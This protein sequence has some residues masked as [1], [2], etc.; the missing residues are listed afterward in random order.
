MSFNLYICYEEWEDLVIE[1]CF[2][3]FLI[4]VRRFL[5]ERVIR[6]LV[7]YY[8]SLLREREEFSY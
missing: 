5:W 3:V 6:F 1:D 8:E 2:Y 7:E 4:F